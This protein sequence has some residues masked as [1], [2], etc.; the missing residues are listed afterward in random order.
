MQE[1]RRKQAGLRRVTRSH[2]IRTDPI[3]ASASQGSEL[4]LRIPPWTRWTHLDGSY[5]MCHVA[6]NAAPRTSTGASSGPSIRCCRVFSLTRPRYPLSD[7]ILTPGSGRAVGVWPPTAPR[8]R[9][10]AGQSLSDE[11]DRVIRLVVVHHDP[12]VRMRCLV[13]DQ[14]RG[15]PAR[16]AASQGVR[17]HLAHALRALKSRDSSHA[18]SERRASRPTLWRLREDLPCPAG[19]PPLGGF[20]VRI[21]PASP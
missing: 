15:L 19:S 1:A 3:D 21:E 9:I 12:L 16:E 7:A 20:H 14:D 10:R 13:R 11:D 6:P 2:T 4:D 8:S 18:G 5:D 17:R